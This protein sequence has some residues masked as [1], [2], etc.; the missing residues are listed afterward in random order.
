MS[1]SAKEEF[2]LHCE[3]NSNEAPYP[4]TICQRGIKTLK[5]ISEIKIKVSSQSAKEELKLNSFLFGKLK[6]NR[7]QSAKEEFKPFMNFS[8]V[9][10]LSVSQSAKEEFKP[11]DDIRGIIEKT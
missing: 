5:I 10:I 9:I 8:S 6:K 3:K 11:M 1:Q 2:K 4:V 7:S